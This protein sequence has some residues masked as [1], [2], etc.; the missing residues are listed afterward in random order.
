MLQEQCEGW[1]PP[2]KKDKTKKQNP[3]WTVDRTSDGS[4]MVIP[5]EISGNYWVSNQSNGSNILGLTAEQLDVSL[6]ESSW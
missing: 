2:N 4:L 6:L 3:I 1:T 5:Q